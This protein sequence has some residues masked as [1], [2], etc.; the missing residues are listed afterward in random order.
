MAKPADPELADLDRQLVAFV[1]SFGLHQPDQTPCGEPIPVSEAH[2]L[3]ELDA[4]GPLSQRELG[5]RLGLAKGTVSRIVD[6]LVAR[7]WVRRVRSTTDARVVHVRLTTAGRAAARRV[8][9]RRRDRLAR[10]LDHLP[11]AERRRVIDALALLT[12]A[13]RADT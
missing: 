12:E 11:T 13:A 7:G 9:A 3:T 4:A 8:A 2:A 5:E 10:L 6:L 1:R